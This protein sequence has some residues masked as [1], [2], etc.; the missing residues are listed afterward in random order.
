MAHH[1]CLVSILSFMSDFL[2]Y[3]LMC[4]AVPCMSHC[5]ATLYLMACYWCQC[6]SCLT[7]SS[8][9]S[10]FT[11]SYIKSRC[12]ATCYIRAYHISPVSYHAT[13]S[14]VKSH[15]LVAHIVVTM[16][17]SIL[18]NVMSYCIMSCY[19]MAHHTF[20]MSLDVYHV[21]YCFTCNTVLRHVTLSHVTSSHG[22]PQLCTA[23]S[24]KV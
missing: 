20:S 6:S 8:V 23:I 12:L 4:H 19:L 9:L 3:C 10:C 7:F 16:S 14:H 2:T 13:Q 21:L 11:L 5:L 22:T 24:F 18:P 15:C 17:Y 1:N